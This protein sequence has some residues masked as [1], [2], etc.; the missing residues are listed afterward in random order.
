MCC[1]IGVCADVK[2]TITA[3]GSLWT[4]EELSTEVYGR[5]INMDYSKGVRMKIQP[6]F[7]SEHSVSLFILEHYVDISAEYECCV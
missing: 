6:S 3:L 5:Y 2:N 4:K 7:N 1:W